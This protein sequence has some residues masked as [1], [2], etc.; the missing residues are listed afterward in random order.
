MSY[1]EEIKRIIK[2]YASIID[3]D[4]TNE[5]VHLIADLNELMIESIDACFEGDP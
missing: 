3:L 1:N 4:E 5:V 2:S